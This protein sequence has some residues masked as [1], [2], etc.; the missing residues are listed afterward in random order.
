MIENEDLDRLIAI[1]DLLADSK[2]KLG[3][4]S[5]ERADIEARLI[6]AYIATGTQ[7]INRNG[8]TV[9]LRSQLWA[10]VAEGREYGDLVAA[11]KI[12]NL[13]GLVSEKFDSSTLSAH[14]REQLAEDDSPERREALVA[15]FNGALKFT[16]LIS[17]RSVKGW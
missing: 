13:G 2:L 17:I 11:L 9:F 15:A 7:R 6:T 12:A 8:R 3:R 14:F 1:D 4:W 5:K 10:G 16:D